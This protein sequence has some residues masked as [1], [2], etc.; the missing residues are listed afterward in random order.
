MPGTEQVLKKYPL[1][2]SAKEPP[3]NE[4][5]IIENLSLRWDVVLIEQT[6][7]SQD[8]VPFP[9]LGGGPAIDKIVT[10]SRI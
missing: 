8:I 9:Q 7:L 6:C 3:K 4:Q 1:N 2:G 10:F 5:A